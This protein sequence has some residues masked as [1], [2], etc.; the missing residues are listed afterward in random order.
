MRSREA[1]VARVNGGGGERTPEIQR[2]SL[3]ASTDYP[4]TCVREHLR[5]GKESPKRM[6]VN[7][8]H[9]SH[10]ARAKEV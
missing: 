1:T 4:Q 3:K 2:D 9:R 8:L 10:R 7:I 5:L 6:K